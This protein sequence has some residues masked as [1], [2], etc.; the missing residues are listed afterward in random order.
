[1]NEESKKII[2][3]D[4][5]PDDVEFF[6]QAV[7]DVCS[8]IDLAIATDGSLLLDL[9]AKKPLPV[10]IVLDLNM[11]VKSGRECLSEIRSNTAFD[12]V[13]VFILSTSCQKQEIDFCLSNGANYYLVK[14]SS[15]EGLKEMIKGI[16]TVMADVK[17]NE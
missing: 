12:K 2:L 15:Y 16:C 10:G 17:L 9:L 5:D 8:D 13:P 6:Q 11:P 4:D 7:S 3:A 1:M 14:P